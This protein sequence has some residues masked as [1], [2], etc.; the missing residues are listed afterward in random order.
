M[1]KLKSSASR[2]AKRIHGDNWAETHVIIQTG[3]TFGISPK[4]VVEVAEKN[5]RGRPISESQVK[6]RRRVVSFIRGQGDQGF[7]V[8]AVT[9]ALK[10]KRMH[11]SNAM[12]WAENS[13]IVKRIGVAPNNGRVGPRD[14]IFSVNQ[15]PN[16]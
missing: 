13:L 3:E 6:V 11:V 16:E 14:V 8:K 15:L 9:K 10:L 2:A 1:Y 5:P 4:V 7:T 12:R